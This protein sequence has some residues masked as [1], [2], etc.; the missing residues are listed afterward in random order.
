MAPR[1]KAAC[2]LP[3]PWLINC[4]MRIYIEHPRAQSTPVFYRLES[5]EFFFAHPYG[6]KWDV[7][8]RLA[9]TQTPAQ[10]EVTLAANIDDGG[11]ARAVDE[12]LG[13]T[14]ASG[15]GAVIICWDGEHFA[16]RAV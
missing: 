16:S 15:E 4:G 5:F 2:T 1:R 3:R 7:R 6:G 9:G 14:G 13:L 12:L 8:G 10:L 11:A